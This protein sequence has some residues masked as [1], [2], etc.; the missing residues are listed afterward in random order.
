MIN[1]RFEPHSHTMYSNIRLL[2]AI[3]DPKELVRRAA[4]LGL[5]GIAITDHE[6]L[7]SHIEMNIYQ[8]EIEKEYP[9]FK[10]A[11]G[12]EIYLCPDREK[13]QKYYHFILIAK[14][15]MGHRALRELSSRTWMLSFRDRGLE[16]VVTTYKD[17]EE[18]TSKYPNSLI[19]TTACLGGLLSS[20]CVSLTEAEQISDN[21]KVKE[22]HDNIVNFMIWCQE[23]F[24][25][26]FYV[27]CAPGQS[28]EQIIANK[29]LR[30]V[31]AAFGVKMVIGTDAHYLKKEDRYVHKAYLTSKEGERE[32]ESFY[33]YSYLQDNDEIAENLAASAY[34]EEFIEQLFENSQ[35]IYSKIEKYSLLHKQTIPKVEVPNYEKKDLV[36]S[37]KYPIL[38]ELSHSDDKINRYWI[39]ECVNKLKEIDK[40]SNTYLSRLE[41]EADIKKTISEKLETNMFAY[42][43][44]LQHYIN[45]FWECGSTV[46]AGRGSAG[47]GLNHF[48]LGITQADPIQWSLPFYRYMN[49][50]RTELGSL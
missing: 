12:D 22:E 25:E 49:K 10:I 23:I 1:K 37:N 3:N 14:N 48:L 2:D 29:R 5:S 24:G 7:S 34:E 4:N 43:I 46:G 16:R 19:A 15:K 18:I 9:D 44:T 20:A 30:N 47:A 41:E 31:A 33:T 11:L 32:V 21:K 36:D 28:K 6:C 39:N 17:I 26:D 50:E 40:Y 45:L 27:E 8:S 38:D 35:E 42:P 13:G